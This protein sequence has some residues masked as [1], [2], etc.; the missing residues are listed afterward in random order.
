[1]A[2]TAGGAEGV[3]AD[4]LGHLA[5]VE[6][7]RGRMGHAVTAAA[8]AAAAFE[9][10]GPR[11]PAP[12]PSPA[13][14]VALAW[15]HLEHYE[16]SEARSRLKEVDA[17]LNGTQDKLIGAVAWLVAAGSSLAEGR[18]AVAAQIIRR[19]RSGWSVPAWLDQRLSQVE[20]RA[21]TASGNIQAALTVAGGPAAAPRWRPRSPWRARGRLPETGRTQRVC[22]HPRWRPWARRPIR[23]A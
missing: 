10:G 14:L 1:V 23:Y 2:A 12:H 8:Q 15:V 16:L 7:M 4:C 19:V 22:S 18:A 5:L 9:A 20:S 21:Y 13:A 11:P 6:A 3:R 17:A